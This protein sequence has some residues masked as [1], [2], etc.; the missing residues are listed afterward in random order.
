MKD[1]KGYKM[2]DT[3]FNIIFCAYEAVIIFETEGDTQRL[4]YKFNIAVNN[5]SVC[6]CNASKVQVSSR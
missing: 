3:T 2:G 5:Y 4:L 6:C 1:M